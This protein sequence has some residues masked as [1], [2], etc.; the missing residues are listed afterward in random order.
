MKLTLI[1]SLLLLSLPSWACWQLK[2][3]IEVNGKIRQ[4]DQKISH[5]KTYSFQQDNL[6]AH[7]KVPTNFEMP[8]GVEKKE[9]AQL[10]QIELVE[11]NGVSLKTLS[12][13]QMIV[14]GNNEATMTMKDS[15][16]QDFTKIT[17]KLEQI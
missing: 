16:T 6:I 13:P 4:I 11:K 8:K 17:L 3:S 2:G 1:I 12:R 10:I 7:I 9:G 14:L 5:N 15:K